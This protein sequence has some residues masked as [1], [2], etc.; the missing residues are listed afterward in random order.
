MLPTRSG[1]FG[2]PQLYSIAHLLVM[3]MTAHKFRDYLSVTGLVHVL[4]IK[5]KGKHTKKSDHAYFQVW[6][7]KKRF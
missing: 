3:H 6:S 4:H 7:L 2:L 1:I 5:M